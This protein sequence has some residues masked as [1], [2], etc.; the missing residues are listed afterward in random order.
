MGP[1]GAGSL[2]QVIQAALAS[3]GRFEE[4][5]SFFEGVGTGHAA[6]IWEDVPRAH[7]AFREKRL[8]QLRRRDV[9]HKPV[10]TF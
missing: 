9:D 8:V 7:E 6:G 10:G 3:R 2:A 1:A 5:R 4:M